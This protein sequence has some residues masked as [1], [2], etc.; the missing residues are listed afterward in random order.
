[1]PHQRRRSRPRR[2]ARSSQWRR[3]TASLSDATHH[4]PPLR[5][6]ASHHHHHHPVVAAREVPERRA[7]LDAIGFTWGDDFDE[8]YIESV[9]WDAFLAIIFTYSKVEIEHGVVSRSLV[10]RCVKQQR[11]V[12]WETPCFCA[13]FS[14]RRFT[15]Q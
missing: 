1:M 14:N 8:K 12:A 7:A 6:F 3:P 10:V 11:C 4:P 13:A 15:S 5:S 2:A 9:N